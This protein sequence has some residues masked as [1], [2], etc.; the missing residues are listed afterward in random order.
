MNDN[1]TKTTPDAQ[2]GNYAFETD[3]LGVV[4]ELKFNVKIG[5]RVVEVVYKPTVL[6]KDHLHLC[7]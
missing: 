1:V 6:L 2:V 7:S 5:D 4:E 3:E